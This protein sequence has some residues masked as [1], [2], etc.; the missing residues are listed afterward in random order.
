MEECGRFMADILG[1]LN[2]VGDTAGSTLDSDGRVHTAPGFTEAYRLYTEAG[3]GAVPFSPEFGGGGF[4]WLVTG[5]MQEMM[6]SPHMAFSLCPPLTPG[7]IET[8]NHHG[9]PAQH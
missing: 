2:R 9:R 1:P 5:V 8:P 7:A 3:W 6:A 4:P